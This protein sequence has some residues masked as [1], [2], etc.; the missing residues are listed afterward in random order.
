MELKPLLYDQK[1]YRSCKFEHWSNQNFNVLLKILKLA[2]KTTYTWSSTYRL[3]GQANNYA[4]NYAAYCQ[5]FISKER[6]LYATVSVTD[7]CKDSDLKS[8]YLLYRDLKLCKNES[9]LRIIYR[10]LDYKYYYRTL[11]NDHQTLN[12]KNIYLMLS[13]QQF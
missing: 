10:S 3:S 12:I 11:N 7:R 5:R 4:D 6:I 1:L 13:N 8:S 9:L 2:Q